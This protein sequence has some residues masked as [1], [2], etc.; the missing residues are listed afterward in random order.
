[1]VGT[2]YQPLQN[3]D[4]FNFFESFTESRFATFHIAG[5]SGNGESVW[6]LEKLRDQV[7]IDKGDLID[8]APMRSRETSAPAYPPGLD[9]VPDGDIAQL[10]HIC[11]LCV[12]G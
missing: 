1:M 7:R 3:L 5:A 11:L 12:Y 8:R 10:A 4:A 6:S 9:P 2:G